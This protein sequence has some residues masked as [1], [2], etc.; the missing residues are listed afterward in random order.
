MKKI[1][2]FIQYTNINEGLID[3][4]M[5]IDPKRMESDKNAYK[6]YQD[7]IVDYQ[8]YK[9][10]KKVKI[11]DDKGSNISFEKIEIGKYYTLSYIFGKYHPVLRDTH[12][13]NVEHGDRRI[14]LT[15]IPFSF[16]IKRNELEQ[17][18]NTS[19]INLGRNVI[20]DVTTT[21]LDGRYKENKSRYVISS[22]M[23][24]NFYNFFINEF[25]VNFPELKTSKYKSSMSIKDIEKGLKPIIEYISVKSKDGKNL[26]TEIRLG[27]DENEIRKLISNMTEEEYDRYWKE[28]NNKLYDP[29]SK[30]LDIR[31]KKVQT[32]IFNLFKENGIDIDFDSLRPRGSI[33]YDFWIDFRYEGDIE[34]ELKEII[35]KGMDGYDM[36]FGRK[37]DAYNNPRIKFYVI[38][39]KKKD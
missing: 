35:K 4:I 6:I 11:L 29:S 10:L 7:V 27:D 15:S 33:D 16:T 3:S 23:A 13:G 18:F 2:N 20:E 37:S 22:D 14:K 34:K 21:T 12:S 31:I 25:N 36:L 5:R 30:A 9:N 24:D 19:R 32:E 26:T 17:M 28:R 1:K 38:N 8:K 39:F